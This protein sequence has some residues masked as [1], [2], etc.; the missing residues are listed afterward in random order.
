[1]LKSIQEF[2]KPLKD[3]FLKYFDMQLWLYYFDLAVT[4]ISQPCLQIEDFR[5]WKKE[6][7]LEKYKDMRLAMCYQ[8][9]HVS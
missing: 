4:F 3:D 7:I 5:D 9:L 1:M 6:W 8:L 2:C